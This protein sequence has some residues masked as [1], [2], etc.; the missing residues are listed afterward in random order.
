MA[1]QIYGDYGFSGEAFLEEFERLD[2]AVDWVERYTRDGDMCGYNRIEVVD[3][4]GDGE[5]IVYYYLNAEDLV[6]YA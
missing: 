6:D 5:L 4:D 3:F 2:D 1:Y